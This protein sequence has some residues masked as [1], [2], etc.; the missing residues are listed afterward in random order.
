MQSAGD[1]L[2]RAFSL[3]ADALQRG[4]LPVFEFLLQ[5]DALPLL[6]LP[7]AFLRGA[8]FLPP[9]LLPRCPFLSYP[10]PFLAG[11]VLQR[12]RQ[13]LPGN[14]FL[15]R[16][17]L[18]LGD[19]LPL[20]GVLLFPYGSALSFLAGAFLG[21]RAVALEL[22]GAFPFLPGAFFGGAF[23][24]CLTVALELCGAFPFLPGAFF[25]GAFLSCLTVALELCGAFPFFPGAFLGGAFLFLA[26]AFRCSAFAFF[27]GGSPLRCDVHAPGS[28]S[29]SGAALIWSP[30]VPPGCVILLRFGGKLWLYR[31]SRL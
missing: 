6:F 14:P 1:F 11:T 31:V 21:G 26:V 19:T 17:L 10:L 27:A 18:A 3:Q 2:F 22:C 8:L 28:T 5:A 23:L 9:S 13:F 25:G 15:L 24:S 16:G 12:A 30:S 20:G 4:P 7:G 29:L